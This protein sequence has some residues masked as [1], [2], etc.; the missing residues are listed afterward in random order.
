[1][2][3]GSGG[4]G[5]CPNPCLFLGP[6]QES[7]WPVLGVPLAR[8]LG[9][10]RGSQGAEFSRMHMC[11]GTQLC[12]TLCDPMDC[13]LEAPQSM[14]FSRQK[15][16]SGLPFPPPGAPP[17]TGI[18]PTS[19]VLPELQADSLPLSRWRSPSDF[20]LSSIISS[21]SSL[22]ASLPDTHRLREGQPSSS[23]A[24]SLEGP[25]GLK[26]Q[27]LPPSL[28]CYSPTAGPWRFHLLSQ[29]PSFILK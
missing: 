15:Y 28:D 9:E 19:P 7:W 16:R 6:C 20:S 17:N 8:M 22:I 5:C 23:G 27:H 1:M 4:K 11:S 18:E 13:S 26:V 29:P 14:E 10:G 21:H 2:S 25:G 24:T 3:G 12:S